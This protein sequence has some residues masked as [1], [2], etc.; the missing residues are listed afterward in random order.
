MRQYKGFLAAF[1]LVLILA[2][3]AQLSDSFTDDFS[4]PS[5][6]WTGGSY[7]TYSYGYVQGQYSFQI[8]V[9]QWFVWST[10]G[11]AY[12]DVTLEVLTTSEGAAD[13]HYGLVCR[14]TGGDFYYF[15]ISADG[16]YG[17]FRKVAG[18][19]LLSL[20]GASMQRS[21]LIHTDG[22]PNRLMA[23][24]EGEQLS[25]FAN[26]EQLVRVQ[27]DTLA[28]GD[29]G[30]AAGTLGQGGT[31]VLFDDLSVTRR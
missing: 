9:P 5:S 17:I 4:D 20:T 30:L 7:E 8:D 11:R 10:A 21:A 23:V 12:D 2:G 19:D 1:V 14:Y 29:V 27:D 6:G 16:Y 26:G 25:F 24:C 3:C 31:L 22:V 18:E 15:A 13:N 28:Q